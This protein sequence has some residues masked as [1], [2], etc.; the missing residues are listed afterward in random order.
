MKK[1]FILQPVRQA[2]GLSRRAGLRP[3]WGFTIIEILVVL[4]I[5]SIL[6]A[7]A[8]PSIKGMQDQA[9]VTRVKGELNTLMIAVESYQ[10]NR[11]PMAY[12]PA[13]GTVCASSLMNAQ[14][15][16]IERVLKDPF[17]PEGEYNYIL[18]GSEKYY[19]LCSAGLNGTPETSVLAANGNLT[20]VGDDI[21]VTNGNIG[22]GTGGC[23]PDC[24]G[25]TCGDDGCGGTCSCDEGFNCEGGSCVAAGDPCD[26]TPDPGTVCTGGA[27]YAGTYGSYKYM[28]TPSDGGTMVWAGE[29]VYTGATSTS[30]GLSNTNNL[31]ARGSGYAA[32]TYC[33]NLSFGG[34][35]DWF[36][37]EQDELGLIYTYNGL[38]G[39]FD[40][41][42]NYPGSYYWSSTEANDDGAWGQNFRY[43]GQGSNAKSLAG[44]VR[45]VRR[46]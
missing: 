46:F 35:S 45:C 1:S 21:C 36:L 31:A 39:G 41:S 30:D 9:K 44:S 14:P 17:K 20:V 38:I 37:P 18:S 12:P 28:T 6:I 7:V 23:T 33:Y 16:L 10:R 34:Y 4:S 8:I 15:Q 24:S 29:F 22:V 40:V 43:G 11:T 13:D 25:N 5:V 3:L 26:G 2:F 27:I 32:A 19:A 42:G